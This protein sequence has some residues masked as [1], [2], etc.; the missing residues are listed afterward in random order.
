VF[1]N[2][3]YFFLQILIIQQ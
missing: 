1:L 2:Y 3:Y